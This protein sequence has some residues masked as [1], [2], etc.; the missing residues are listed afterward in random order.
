MH[1]LS[2]FLPA[3]LT[4][5]AWTGLR[6]APLAAQREPSAAPLMRLAVN[7]AAERAGA[8]SASTPITAGRM[9]CGT[10]RLVSAPLGAGA[11]ALGTLV[12]YEL[13]AASGTAARTMTVGPDSRPGMSDR[14]RL[15]FVGG[16]L[17]LILG[18]AAP[19]IARDCWIQLPGRH[20][21]ESRVAPAAAAPHGRLGITFPAT[22]SDAPADVAAGSGQ[23]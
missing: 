9:S 17:G 5:L 7:G 11:G 6:A 23:P 1:R 22:A 12:L 15:V 2:R 19:P 10:A 8:P 3:C 21:G 4:V 13:L 16:T 14:A 18:I 20:G